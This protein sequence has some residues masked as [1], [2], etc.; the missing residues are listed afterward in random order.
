MGLFDWMFKSE[1]EKRLEELRKAEASIVNLGEGAI[2]LK[3]DELKQIQDEINQIKM[4]NPD[5]ED[6]Q[7]GFA[8]NF[9]QGGGGIGDIID[10]V[11]TNIAANKL[12]DIISS[13]DPHGLATSQI[14]TGDIE[15]GI[16]LAREGDLEGL[17][18]LFYNEVAQGSDA[19]S[20]AAINYVLKEIGLSDPTAPYLLAG[21]LA[22]TG[23]GQI[24]NISDVIAGLNL[25]D[26][27][28]ADTA[29]K[30]L[31]IID[32]PIQWTNKELIKI[33]DMANKMNVD[34]KDLLWG[35]KPGQFA[36]TTAGL[37]FDFFADNV[38][39]NLG[40]PTFPWSKKKDPVIEPPVVLPPEV[41]SNV[42]TGGTTPPP[43]VVTDTTKPWESDVGQDTGQTGGPGGSG[44]A[45]P[46]PPSNNV[47]TSN[48]TYGNVINRAEGGLATIPRY[49]KGR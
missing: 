47:G 20:D 16:N 40:M 3:K 2:E 22:K 17:G 38:L 4:D 5:N 11:G 45:P 34:I 12:G 39:Y 46:P 29:E 21:N 18:S 26:N 32:K 42:V 10:K 1:E 24:A 36:K 48:M 44:F 30:G 28:I 19:A 9:P 8:P 41:V 7:S 49:L 37:P 6:I 33:M 35:S 14:E 43:I 15:R 27:K 31:D 13:V 23:T 25:G